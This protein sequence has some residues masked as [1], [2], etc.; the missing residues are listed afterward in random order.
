MKL[1]HLLPSAPATTEYGY[2]FRE[3][4]ETG[5]FHLRF[6]ADEY[7]RFMDVTTWLCDQCFVLTNTIRTIHDGRDAIYAVY[8][9]RNAE[10]PFMPLSNN[11]LLANVEGQLVIGDLG[12]GIDASP[13][14]GYNVGQMRYVAYLSYSELELDALTLDTEVFAIDRNGKIVLSEWNPAKTK[15][16]LEKGWRLR[17]D[18]EE[19]TVLTPPNAVFCYG[20]KDR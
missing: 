7:K 18:I 4:I 10:N 19:H 9:Y 16:M 14:Y 6:F 11:A 13:M 2:V 5:R 15:A 20:T 1:R 3:E 17:L 8:S 12:Y